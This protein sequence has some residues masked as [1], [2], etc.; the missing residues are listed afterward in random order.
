MK[1][2]NGEGEVIKIKRKKGRIGRELN[3]DRREGGRVISILLFLSSGDIVMGIR[4]KER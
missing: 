4:I 3:G 1:S 2:A